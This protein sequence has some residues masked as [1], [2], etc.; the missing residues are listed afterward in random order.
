MVQR[1]PVFC[2]IFRTMYYLLQ[3]DSVAGVFFDI[4]GEVFDTVV[5]VS[6]PILSFVCF[7]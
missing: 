3:P 7:V 5:T 2:D 4:D 1:Q 6:M